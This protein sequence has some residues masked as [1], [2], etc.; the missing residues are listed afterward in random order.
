MEVTVAMPGGTDSDSLGTLGMLQAPLASTTDRQ[1]Q[2][3]LSVSTLNPPSA[4]ATAVT[5]VWVSTG[6]E[7]TSA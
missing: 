2:S 1:C 3:P 5:R 6:A 4:S 7:M